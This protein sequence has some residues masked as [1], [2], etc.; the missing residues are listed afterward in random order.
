[1]EDPLYIQVEN[2]VA[3]NHPA[4]ASNLLHALGEIPS[5]WEPFVRVENP[6]LPNSNLILLKPEPEYQKVNGVWTDVWIYREKTQ[7]ELEK[8]KNEL[9][10]IKRRN[11]IIQRKEYFKIMPYANNF[12]AWT[13]NEE[14]LEFEPPF[15]KPNDG[16]CY[17]WSGS[18]N[19]WKEAEPYPN[20]GKRYGFDFD[21]WIN[22]EITDE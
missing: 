11:K 1:M 2:G 17:R 7:E 22:V 8:E 14:T 21:N 3:I 19:N 5:N 15:P 9:D 18:E 4:Y 16:K 12:T 10:E 20:D 6:V 13:F